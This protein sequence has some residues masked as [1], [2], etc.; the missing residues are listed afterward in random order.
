[1]PAERNLVI[2]AT[3]LMGSSVARPADALDWAIGRL[4]TPRLIRS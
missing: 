1:M 3:G 4:R 2:G